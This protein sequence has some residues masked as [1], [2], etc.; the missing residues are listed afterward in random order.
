MV[1]K[2]PNQQ[3]EEKKAMNTFKE[4]MAQASKSRK[5]KLI[6]QDK[7]RDLKAPPSELN[8]EQKARADGLLSRA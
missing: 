7:L 8:I 3:F 6:Y 2:T 5:D 1:I 4:T